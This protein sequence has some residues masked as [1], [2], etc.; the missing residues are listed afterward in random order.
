MYD[1]GGG[2]DDFAGASCGSEPN[3]GWGCDSVYVM[4]AVGGMQMPGPCY[5]LPVLPVL[6]VA[7]GCVGS[8]TSASK[9]FYTCFHQSGSDWNNLATTLK[10][11]EKK[12][13]KDPKCD[14]FLTSS[15]LSMADINNDLLN[16][17]STFTLAGAI[18]SISTGNVLAG[19]TFDV[20][21]QTPI[22]INSYAFQKSNQPTNYLTILHELAHLAAVIPP[23]GT[24]AS[25]AANDLTVELNCFK[26][27]G[28]PSP[29]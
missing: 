2:D 10:Q 29:Q 19:T 15:G 8:Y 21:S 25:S 24:P 13:Q 5:F 16:P 4:T 23:D 26:T 28:I 1:G 9:T 11:I 14:S 12:L 17:Y 18:V 3:Q 27:I 7:A 6:P 22:I 20:P